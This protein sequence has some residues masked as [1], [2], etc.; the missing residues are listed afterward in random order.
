MRAKRGLRDDLAH[1][2]DFT[3]EE[4]GDLGERE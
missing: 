1:S 3:G 4:M 2:S